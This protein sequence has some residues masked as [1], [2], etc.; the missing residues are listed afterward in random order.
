MSLIGTMYKEPRVFAHDAIPLN[1]LPDTL[2][3][4]IA[5]VSIATALPAGSGYSGASNMIMGG[6]SGCGAEIS[7]LVIGGEIQSFV[8]PVSTGSNYQVGDVLTAT[9]PGASNDVTVTVA[10]LATPT[11]WALGDPIVP[12]TPCETVPS[13]YTFTSTAQ[14]GIVKSTPGPGV[15]LYIGVA[16]DITVIMESGK[17]V[18]FLGVA[19]GTFLPISV[20]SVVALSGPTTAQVLTIY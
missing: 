10:T 15:G 20:L 6:G 18:V 12:M 13:P 2:T 7:A 9:Q 3:G 4:A 14:P 1:E 17:E 8:N 19:A 5:T 11:V 16:G